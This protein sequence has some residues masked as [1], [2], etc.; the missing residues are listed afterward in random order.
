MHVVAVKR[1]G[2]GDRDR[3]L[4]GALHIETGL[5]L[6]LGAVHAVVEHAHRDHILEHLAQRVGIDL[7]VPRAV[8]LVVIAEHAHEIGRQRMRLRR[9]HARV[10]TRSASRGGNDNIRKVRGIAG[11]VARFGHV[12]LEH[13]PVG[14]GRFGI[15]VTHVEGALNHKQRQRQASKTSVLYIRRAGRWALT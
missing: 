2:G 12:Q 14:A 6:P 8:G 7:R 5:P 9:G 11:T 1:G 10:G 4:A 3:F 15:L 13:W